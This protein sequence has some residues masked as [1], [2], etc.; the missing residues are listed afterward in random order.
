VSDVGSDRKVWME[1]LVAMDKNCN[2]G[3]YY[4][5]VLIKVQWNL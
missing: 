1:L 2:V 4:L 3:K 5:H